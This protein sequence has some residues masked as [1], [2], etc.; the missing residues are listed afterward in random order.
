VKSRIISALA[1]IEASEDVTVLYACESGSRAWGFASTDSDY[2]VRFIY[3]HRPSWYLSVDL[4]SKRDVIERP[5]EELLDISG[6]DLRKTLKLLRKSNPPLIEWLGSP[7]VYRETLRSA[8]KL[9]ELS[10]SFYSPTASGYH[11]LHM[12]RGNFR[13][14]LKGDTVWRKKYFYVLR[15]LLAIKWLE[16]GLGV[17]PTEFRSLVD[18]L[19]QPGALLSAINDLVKVKA[20]GG[21]LDNG[22]RIPEI[23]DFVEAEISR[24]EGT[25]F[26]RRPAV[27]SIEPLNE[28]F[29]QELRS[30][31]GDT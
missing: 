8:S 21:E 18:E 4:E 2:D 22:P 13:E 15:P 10:K 28:F 27:P 26:D 7:I 25:K 24:L 14:Y 20:S 1:E 6:W 16:A 19:V 29:Q 23:S 30:V 9:R 17:V 11:Y 3:L 5:I 12:A 31:Y